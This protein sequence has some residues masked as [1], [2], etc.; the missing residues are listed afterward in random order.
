[1]R[2]GILGGT[3]NPIHLAHLAIAEEARQACRLDRVIFLPAADPP[4]KP[5]A[6]GVAFCHRL[7][8]V[9][10]ALAGNPAFCAS[11][12][13]A[14]RSGK[15]YSVE[16]LKI[17]RQRFP[18]DAFY[19]IIGLDSFRDLTTWK[20]YE[21]LFSLTNLVVASR[22]GI[23]TDPRQLLPIAIR[24]QFCY[25]AESK[26]LLHD[27]GHAVIFLEETRLEI[28]STEIRNRIAAQ[29]SIHDLVPGP[30]AEYIDRHGLYRRTDHC[31]PSNVP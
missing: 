25:S 2:T 6:A 17:L 28:S 13:E 18:E 30:V 12:L 9:E 22:P 11:D 19:F 20:A 3:F 31:S 21:K 16:T 8:M 15:S 26:N 7:A 14:H 5:I 4:H 23:S 10:L 24:Q 27:S 29:Q 1:M